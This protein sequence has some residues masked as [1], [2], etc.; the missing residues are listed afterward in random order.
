M[1]FRSQI[2]HKYGRI[3]L[4][5][6]I[7][8]DINENDKYQTIYSKIFGSVAAPT[9]GFH[10]SKEIFDKL[11]NN[12]IRKYY[13]TL[14]IGMGTFRPIKSENFNEHKMDCEKYFIDDDTI[15]MLNAEKNKGRKILAVGTTSARTLEDS[16]DVNGILRKNENDTDLFIYP[17]YKFKFVEKLLTNFHLPKSTLF[18][19]VSAFAGTE[20]IKRAYQ[21][22]IKEKY[23]FYSFGDAMLII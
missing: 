21:Q 13:V 8:E 19:L 16:S 1:L 6:Y 5:P 2:I 14:H 9:A 3:P 15:A 12:G 22:A 18:L 17:G 11:E 7:R 4:P 10:F 20:I 23:R